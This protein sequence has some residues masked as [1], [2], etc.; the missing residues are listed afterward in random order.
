MHSALRSWNSGFLP[1]WIC[2]FNEKKSAHPTLYTDKKAGTRYAAPSNS[3]MP[4]PHQLYCGEDVGFI[5]ED[6][7]LVF[8]CLFVCLFVFVCSFVFK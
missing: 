6:P 2:E 1:F 3:N 8:V 5:Q 7:V 4:G